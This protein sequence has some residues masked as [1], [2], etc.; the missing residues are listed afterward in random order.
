MR[1]GRVHIVA[2]RQTE[3]VASAVAELLVVNN[4]YLESCKWFSGLQIFV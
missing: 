1:S 4:Q 3:H 2:D